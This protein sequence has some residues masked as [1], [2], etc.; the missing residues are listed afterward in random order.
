MK[1]SDLQYMLDVI[2][3]LLG[4]AGGKGANELAEFRAAL[5]PFRDLTAK[6]LTN[7]LRK[8][9]EAPK[10]V[11]QAG[12]K[13]GKGPFIDVDALIVQMSALYD[14]A[15]SPTTTHAEVEEGTNRLTGLG[16]ND[17][18]RVAEAIGLKGMKSK[19]IP[20]IVAEIRQRISA[21]L[22]AGQRM[23]MIDVVGSAP[24]IRSY[25]S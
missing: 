22:G 15:G 10:P 14:R 11:K 20:T 7:E 25:T 5:D 23:E 1:V 2:R 17:I 18:V 16:K 9:T 8:L 6:Q 3:Q 21:R 19:T 24:P 12:K 13:S 4:S